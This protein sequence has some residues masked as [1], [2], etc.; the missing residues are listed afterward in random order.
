MKLNIQTKLLGAFGVMIVLMIAVFGVGF[1]GLSSVAG[2]TTEIVTEDLVQDVGVREL[3]VL[4]LE[5][6]ATY[7]DF[8]IT[9]NEE[10]LVD[11]EH[12]TEAVFEHFDVLEEEF[13]GNDELLAL[14]FEVEDEYDIFLAAGD[15]LI[16]LVHSGAGDE[17][18]IHELEL[19][20]EDERLLEEELGVLATAVEHKID[21]AFA[22]ALDAKSLA[23]SIAIGALVIAAL[24]GAALAIFLS[25]GMAGGMGQMLRAA[26]GMAEGDL[27]Q[28]LNVTSRDE[29]GAT[30]A[31][32][33][34][35]TD[36]L[37]GMAGVAERI[38]DG[39]L[40]VSVTPKS[41]RDTLGNAFSGMIDSL[42]DMAG[43]AERIA[44]GD[45]TANVT[46]KS[47]QD[48][49]GNAFAR[50]IDNLRDL[51]GRVDESATGV[52]GASTQL[53]SAA[54]QAGQA[55]TAIA[56]SAQ[57]GA[58]GAEQQARSVQDTAGII[59]ELSKAAEQVANGSA[60]QTKSIDQASTIGGQVAQAIVDVSTNAQAATEGARQASDAARA[61]AEVLKRNVEGMERIRAAVRDASEKISSLGQQSAE[62]GKIVAVIDDV[63]EQTNLLALNAAIEAARA[64]EQG[65][66]FAVV[67]DEVRKLAERVSGATSEIATL[68]ENVQAGVEESVKATDEGAAQV[69]EGS[70]LVAEAGEALDTILTSA[71]DVAARIEQISAAAEEV[72]ASSDEMV[73]V[74]EGVGAVTQENSAAAEQMSASTAQVDTAIEGVA[75]ITEQAS[76]AS[77]ETSASAEEM[78][79][80]VEE[81]VASAGTLSNMAAD[82]KAVVGAFKLTRDDS[83]GHKGAATA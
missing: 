6:T 64:G 20:E 30:A 28:T 1:W 22:E 26:E 16:D 40:T 53:S 59:R 38:A 82:L 18:I 8:I 4:I 60:S 45:L 46:P 43:V 80:Q 76:A 58:K 25:R 61:G 83:S 52:A 67:A 65:R 54:E 13:H 66:G 36:Y 9:E 78:S 73:K 21:V 81:V 37:K 69:E 48:A 75:A 27:N 47:E 74:L 32:F 68:I 71:E 79:A 5:Q 29:V 42:R 7:E 57:D 77:Q 44:D 17:A 49:L 62:I 15:E 10:D 50:M 72:A 56:K 39:D 70:Q 34:T 63:A 51:V 55:T 31:A 19:L 14:L 3:E 12:E 35:M 23:T 2:H 11:I 24:T 41:E 33:A